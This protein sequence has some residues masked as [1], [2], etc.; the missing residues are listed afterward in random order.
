[1]KE[2]F[3]ASPVSVD[4]RWVCDG[5]EALDYLFQRGGYRYPGSA[6]R[7]DLILLDLIM[8]RKG[9]LET[10]NQIKGTGRLRNIPVVLLATCRKQLHEA[11][12]LRLGADSFIVKPHDFDELVNIFAELH[13]HYFAIFC[14]PDSL[15]I[16]G[17][18]SSNRFRSIRKPSVSRARYHRSG[19]AMRWKATGMLE[20]KN[21]ERKKSE[22]AS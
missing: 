20:A 3:E 11:S 19:V 13:E 15:E 17:L 12:G 2:T 6:P 21:E 16:N 7:P 9:G 4:L 22:K 18:R 10:L 5:E 14:M 1:M 8:P